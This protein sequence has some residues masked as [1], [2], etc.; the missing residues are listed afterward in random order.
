MSTPASVSTLP[1]C[2]I[3]RKSGASSPWTMPATG[4]YLAAKVKLPPV[5]ETPSPEQV[6]QARAFLLDRFLRDF[7]W[8]SD[9][10][11]ANYIAL[12][13]TPIVRYYT[14]SLTPF[15]LIDATMPASGK[16]ILTGGPGM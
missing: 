2:V 4:L 13:A 15:A 9:A 12:L 7:L 14:R 10:D 16:T 1:T 5:P 6:D 8:S 3:E 11:R